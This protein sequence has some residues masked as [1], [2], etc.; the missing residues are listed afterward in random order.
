[1]NVRFGSKAD[2]LRASSEVRFTSES[3]HHRCPLC[4]K[5][6]HR[7]DARALSVEFLRCGQPD[8]AIATSDKDILVR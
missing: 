8:P 4:A 7:V 1:L 6:G 2:I 5:S 3:G